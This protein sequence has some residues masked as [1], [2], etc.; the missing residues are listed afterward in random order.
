MYWHWQQ[1]LLV[2]G[3]V[4]FL[5]L[6]CGGEPSEEEAVV[7]AA[8]ESQTALL[9]RDPEAFCESMTA[10]RRGKLIADVAVLSGGT[11][12]TDAS[13]VV[14]DVATEKRL[15]EVEEAR[16]ELTVEDVRVDGD[17][18]VVTYPSGRQQPFA[19]TAGGWLVAGDA[20]RR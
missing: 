9:E 14:F 2:V 1:V 11:G 12:C 16:D 8:K 3:L 6:G 10:R 17:R 4:T 5:F 19:K 20:K 7:D 13:E 15:A 18:A